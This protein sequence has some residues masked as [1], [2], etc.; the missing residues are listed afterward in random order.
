MAFLAPLFFAALITFAVPVIIHLTQREK[1]QVIEFPSL[2][3]L[4]RIPYQSVRRRRIR[5]WP[6][7]AMRLAAIAL[8]VLAFARPFMTKSAVALA[9]TMGP[10]EVVVLLDHSYSI[11][12]QATVGTARARLRGARSS[13]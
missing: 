1:K 8:I 3:F 6:L 9:S 10:R 7:L 11:S 13:R 5:D 2:M 12:V 4:Q